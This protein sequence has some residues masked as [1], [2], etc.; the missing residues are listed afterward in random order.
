MAT[1]P[2][3]TAGAVL[4]AAQMN[5]VG[6][7]LVKTQTVGTAVPNVIVYD[8]FS[9][10][11]D[12]YKITYSGGSISSTGLIYV[13][14]GSANTAYFGARTA[15]STSNAIALSADNNQSS[16][17]FGGVGNTSFT[18][19]DFEI[20]GPFASRRTFIQSRYFEGT[21]ALGVYTGYQDSNTS[22]TDFTLTAQPSRTLTGGTIRVYGY[23]N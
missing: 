18:Q 12:N 16:W 6:L 5:V 21:G 3:F 20:L 11:F 22:F 8:A 19:L 17:T 2:D 4:T 10:D 13:S 9:A 14:L 1:P 7:W 23:R 15:S